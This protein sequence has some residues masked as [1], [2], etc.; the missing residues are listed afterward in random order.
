MVGEGDA[1]GEGE[2]ADAAGDGAAPEGEAEQDEQE[3]LVEGVDFGDDVVDPEAARQAVEQGGGGH[4][5]GRQAEVRAEGVEEQQGQEAPRAGK[6]GPGATR[7]LRAGG[8]QD[9]GEGIAAEDVEGI[10]GHVQ[11]TPFVEDDL[12]FAGV[13]HEVVAGAV[14]DGLQGGEVEEE[15]GEQGRERPAASARAERGGACG[16]G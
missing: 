3:Q 7:G 8:A 9:G 13:E 6:P 5:P 14:G 15:E 2:P 12:R 4:Q 16:G 11:A 10:A 1:A